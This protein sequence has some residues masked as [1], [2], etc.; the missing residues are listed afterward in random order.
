MFGGHQKSTLLSLPRVI[1]SGQSQVWTLTSL[2]P[3]LF[4]YIYLDI[5]QFPLSLNRILLLFFRSKHT[6]CDATWFGT[7]LAETLSVLQL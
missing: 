3:L 7:V 5:N 6:Q 2:L 1:I 4:I